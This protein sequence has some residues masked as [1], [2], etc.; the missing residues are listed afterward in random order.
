MLNT[1]LTFGSMTD[2]KT[3]AAAIGRA[4]RGHRG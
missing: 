2:P 4:C 3:S 1:E